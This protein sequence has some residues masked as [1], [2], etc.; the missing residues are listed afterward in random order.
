MVLEPLNAKWDGSARL[1]RLDGEEL[2]VRVKLSGASAKTFA[3]EPG[4][5]YVFSGER[6]ILKFPKP[7]DPIEIKVP[8]PASRSKPI[9]LAFNWGSEYG[10]AAVNALRVAGPSPRV[11]ASRR[12][13]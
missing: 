4:A 11:A 7:T 8:L 3:S 9:D 10:P 12:A 5:L 2:R 6:E 13:R 1:W